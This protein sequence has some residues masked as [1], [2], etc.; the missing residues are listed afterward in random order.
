MAR[1]EAPKIVPEYSLP[2]TAAGAVDTVS[3][4]LAKS[5]FVR[6]RLTLVALMRGPR[7]VRA[8][9]KYGGAVLVA[10]I[11]EVVIPASASVRCVKK[12]RLGQA[13]CERCA[14]LHVAGGW[15]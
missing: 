9:Q 12:S 1:V 5:E 6:E 3:T 14:G 15:S 2:L 8:M 7:R 10:S 11:N 13:L 4:E